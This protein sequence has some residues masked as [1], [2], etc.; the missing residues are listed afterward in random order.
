MSNLEKSGKDDKLIQLK[1]INPIYFTLE[2]SHL[3]I[4]GK[5]VNNGQSKNI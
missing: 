1:N 5:E 3:D 4:S 2:I